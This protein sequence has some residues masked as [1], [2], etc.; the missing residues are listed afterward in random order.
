MTAVPADDH[1]LI[2]AALLWFDAG[3]AVVPSHEDGTKR[4]WGRW[5]SYQSERMGWDD[6]QALLLTDRHTGIGAIIGKASDNT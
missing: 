3:Y 4:P 6:L 5:K 1:P 2:T